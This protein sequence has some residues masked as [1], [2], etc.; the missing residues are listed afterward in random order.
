MWYDIGEPFEDLGNGIYDE[1]EPFEDLPIIHKGGSTRLYT[2]LSNLTSSQEQLFANSSDNEFLIGVSS[3]NPLMKSLWHSVLMQM[4]NS[5]TP[6][7]VEIDSDL[8][9]DIDIY[10]EGT[11]GASATQT[12]IIANDSSNKWLNAV[13]STDDYIFINGSAVAKPASANLPLALI[14]AAGLA[15]SLRSI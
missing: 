5:E 6:N 4:Q 1:G 11:G 8:D 2:N 9:G 14:K 15:I 13:F 7:S 10:G 3:Q 12:R